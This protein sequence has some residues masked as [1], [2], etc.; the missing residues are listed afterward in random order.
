MVDMQTMVRLF[1]ERDIKDHKRELHSKS[2]DLPKSVQ[3]VGPGYAND[4]SR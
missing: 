2:T 1:Y 4:P 3:S